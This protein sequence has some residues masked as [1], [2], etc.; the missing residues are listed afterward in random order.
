MARLYE[1]IRTE[2][3][4]N[5]GCWDIF[6]WRDDDI[7]FAESKWLEKGDSIRDSQLAWL[8]AA[9]ANGVSSKSFFVYECER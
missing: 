5:K 1:I 9:L 8:E 7:L 4:L 3:G 2:S 6:V